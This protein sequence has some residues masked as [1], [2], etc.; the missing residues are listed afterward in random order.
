[1]ASFATAT[2]FLAVFFVVFAAS[3][4]V[5]RPSLVRACFWRSA[6]FRS[7]ADSTRLPWRYPHCAPPAM[8]RWPNAGLSE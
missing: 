8:R 4:L 2:R 6:K 5:A 1:M 7:Y 3:E